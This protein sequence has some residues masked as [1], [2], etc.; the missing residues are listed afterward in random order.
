M[1]LSIHLLVRLAVAAVNV[2]PMAVADH[3]VWVEPGI[4]L[5][6]GCDNGARQTAGDFPKAV[7]KPGPSEASASSEPATGKMPAMDPGTH[8]EAVDPDGSLPTCPLTGPKLRAYSRHG[9]GHP[10]FAAL[11]LPEHA[12]LR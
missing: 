2:S 11:I 5:S 9:Q 1:R 4:A 10:A 6:S 12:S 3:D 7:T 8:Q